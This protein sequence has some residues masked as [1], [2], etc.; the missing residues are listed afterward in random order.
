MSPEEILHNLKC[1]LAELQGQEEPSFY[2]RQVLAEVREA[3]ADLEASK[4]YKATL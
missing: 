3:I 4:E 1:L 2:W